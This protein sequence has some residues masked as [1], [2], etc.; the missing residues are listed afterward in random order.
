M[1]RALIESIIDRVK[2]ELPQFK[3]VD[4]YNSQ[5]D[6][7]DEGVID[8][9]RF[10]ALFLS[11]PDGA[12]YSNFAGKIQQSNDVTVRF[13]I[14]DELTKS[15]LSISK[16]VNEIMDLKQE[17]FKKFHG[18]GNTT[19]KAMTRIYEETDE[20]RKNYYVFIQDYKTNVIDCDNY[21]DMGQE[22]T[23]GLD[24][25]TEVVINPS[26]DEDIRTARDTN[27]NL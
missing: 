27:D 13:Y 23:L 17:V 15:R 6:K 24:L 26:T 25:T 9:Y 11:F 8:S 22:V 10:P 14:A 12:D 7:Q 16:T 18:W 1:Q 21:I 20:D 4:V 5:F 2:A 3:T 19:I